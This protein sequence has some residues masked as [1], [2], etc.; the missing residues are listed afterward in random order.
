MKLFILSLI[1]AVC[2]MAQAVITTTPSA[3]VVY[4]GEPLTMTLSIS[5]GTQPSGI[6]WTAPLQDLTAT[7]G[8]SG[9]AAA[10]TAQCATVAGKTNCIIYGINSNKILDGAV[11][12]IAIPTATPGTIQFALTNVLGSDAAGNAIPITA[13][14]ATVTVTTKCDVNKSGTT[15]A[16]DVNAY[17]PQVIGSAPCTQ[18]MTGDGK[19]DIRSLIVLIYGAMPGGVCSAK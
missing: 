14:P 5:G 17:L 19:C 15:D 4:P 6:Q 9:T 12:S 2:A 7:I 18:S 8:A 3:A 10:K 13:P 11:A 1:F 16:A